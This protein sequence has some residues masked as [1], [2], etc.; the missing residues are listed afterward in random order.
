MALNAKQRVFVEEYVQ[1][2]NATEAALRAGYSPKTAYAIGHNQLKKV[3]VAAAIQEKINERA[4]T[5]DEVLIR[6]AEQARGIPN[7]C[8]K[9]EGGKVLVD[10]DA[11]KE[12]GLLHL[13][14]KLSYDSEGMP[15]VE[16]YDAQGALGQLAKVHGLLTERLQHSGEV[17]INV[18]YEDMNGDSE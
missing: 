7:E 8:F 16:F 18:V 11:L 1:C 9:L 13:I 6:L 12:R 10:F 5:A 14:K 3:E 15:R 17:K 4:M 2:W